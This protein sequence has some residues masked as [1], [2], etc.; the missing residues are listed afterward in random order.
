MTTLRRLYGNSSSHC[1]TDTTQIPV[2][3][4]THGSRRQRE[5]SGSRT[6]GNGPAWPEGPEIHSV[7]PTQV[8]KKSGDQKN[9]CL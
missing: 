4:K 6:L 2:A 8:K 1:N 3:A 9:V 7:A 5:D